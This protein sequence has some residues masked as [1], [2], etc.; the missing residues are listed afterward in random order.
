MQRCHWNIRSQQRTDVSVGYSPRNGSTGAAHVQHGFFKIVCTP[1]R[2]SISPTPTMPIYDVC[3]NNSMMV[4]NSKS[5]NYFLALVESVYAQIPSESWLSCSSLQ[6]TMG[7]LLLVLRTS[8]NFTVVQAKVCFS[9]AY[10]QDCQGAC[11]W[12]AA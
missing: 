12:C 11:V 9:A 7:V 5:I 10:K 8:Q 1:S 6:N 2:I 4:I 3:I